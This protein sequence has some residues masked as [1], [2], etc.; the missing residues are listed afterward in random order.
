M[1]KAALLSKWH[2]H[3]VDYA[4]QAQEQ[5]N[6]SIEAVWDEEKERGDQWA[7]EL[8]VPF[9]PDL[10]TVLLNSEIDAVIVTTPTISHKDVIVS[11]AKHKKHIFTEKVLA[12]TVEECNEILAEV[13]KA[14]VQLM[15][16]LPRLVESYYLYAQ[17]ALDKGWLGQLTM[18]RCRMAHNG[19]VASADHPDGWLP[20]HFY[21]REHTGGGAFIDLGAHPIYLA[22]RLAGTPQ[23][24]M[25][26]LQSVFHQDV[27]D[28]AAVIVD[29]ESGTLGI[30]ET[31]F[32]SGGSPF[33]LELYGTEGSILIEQNELRIKSSH[34]N[35]KDWV[36]PE[37]MMESLPMPLVQWVN[38]IEKGEEPTITKEDALNLTLVNEGAALS[39]KEGRRVDLQPIK[40]SLAR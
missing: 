26:R 19:A 33:Q 31:S 29:Y 6:L 5:Q 37:E 15:V 12:L 1:I 27:D 39:E 2:V 28:Q 7:Q 23:A 21:E 10:E 34:L 20:A 38:A 24:V 3:A 16:S 35:T 22:N 9:E 17:E 4:K 8:G 25:A 36:K 11:A 14:G 18:V 32:V 13:E 40:N 30:L